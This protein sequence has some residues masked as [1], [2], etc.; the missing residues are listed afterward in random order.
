M[1]RLMGIACNDCR[2]PKL[3]LGICGEY[4]GESSLIAICEQVGRDD[5]SCSPFRV[6]L[7]NWRRPRPCA[8][9][10]ALDLQASR[11]TDGVVTREL[12]AREHRRLLSPFE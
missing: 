9:S 8:D 5:V 12:E 10:V 4:G 6:P 7:P 2:K 11:S 3:K 1:G